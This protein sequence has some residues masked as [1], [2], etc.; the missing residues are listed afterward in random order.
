MSM[1]GDS[2]LNQLYKLMDK[3][4]NQKR[5]ANT[6]NS[7]LQKTV[8]FQQEII[9][10]TEQKL[11]AAFATLTEKERLFYEK[12]DKNAYEAAAQH[13]IATA[14]KLADEKVASIF[15][16]PEFQSKLNMVVAKT[17]EDYLKD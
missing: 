4:N 7:I 14:E 15:N 10:D 2:Q 9:N 13:V 16:T 8:L 11:K 6:T 3:S 12:F 5:L 1:Y 17:I